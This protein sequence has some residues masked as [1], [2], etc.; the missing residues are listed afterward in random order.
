MAIAKYHTL[1]S[2]NNRHVFLRVLKSGKCEIRV[3]GDSVS[4]EILPGLH[5][6]IF[7][8]YSHMAEKERVLVSSPSCKGTNFIMRILPS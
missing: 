6:A 1:G 7:S 4:G 5:M 2:L 3:L 8:L